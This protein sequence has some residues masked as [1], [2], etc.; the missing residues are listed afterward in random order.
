LWPPL[1]STHTLVIKYNISTNHTSRSFQ[2]QSNCEKLQHV[3]SMKKKYIY[4]FSIQYILTFWTCRL[5]QFTYAT[6]IKYDHKLY[7]IKISIPKFRA[8]IKFLNTHTVK[9]WTKLNFF[10]VCTMHLVGLDNR[11]NFLFVCF[12]KQL[13]VATFSLHMLVCWW[14]KIHSWPLSVYIRISNTS[15]WLL[16]SMLFLPT[17]LYTVQCTLKWGHQ[18]H[19][20]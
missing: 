14:N 12:H 1:V 20:F 19:G 18:V 16:V 17:L 13:H 6:A 4:I 3:N 10:N 15:E 9:W 7:N 5:W 8:D 2:T 11:V